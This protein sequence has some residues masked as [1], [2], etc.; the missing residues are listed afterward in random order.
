MNNINREMDKLVMCSRLLRHSGVTQIVRISPAL[1]LASSGSSRWKFWKKEEV[2]VEE[3]EELDELEMFHK[4]QEEYRME[5]EAERMEQRR[6]KSRLSA[7]HRQMLRGEPPN[8]GLRFEYGRVHHSQEFKR[9]MFGTYG[10][11]RTDVDPGICWPT[12]KH[13]E[14]ASEW[15]KLYQEKPLID[16]IKDAKAGIA[17][18]KEDRMKRE[19]A[20]EAGLARMDAQIKQWK[21]RVNTKNAQAEHERARREKVLAELREEFGYNVNPNDN[22]MKE[23]IAER[24][25]ALMKEEKEAKKAARKEKF[26]DKAR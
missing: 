17:K 22:Y 24:E 11:K 3:V 23:R 7:S 1:R 19:A 10:E 15:E 20:V 21:A 14:L 12:D 26:G 18:R 13:L 8:V 9:K 2:K 6:N 16:Q 25:K 4:Q 5:E